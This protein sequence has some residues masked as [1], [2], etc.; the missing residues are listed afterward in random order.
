[1]YTI[2][3]TGF[4]PLCLNL[5]FLVVRAAPEVA[6]FLNQFEGQLARAAEVFS[7][8]HVGTTS[9]P[10]SEWI[11]LSMASEASSLS[12]IS[13][14]LAQFREAGP[15]AGLDPQSIQALKWDH[16]Q[17]KEDIES[18]LSRR[19]S[20]RSRIVATNEKEAEWSR[21]KPVSADSGCTTRLEEKVLA[22]L[23]AALTCL[24]DEE[25]S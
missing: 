21:Q 19:Q 10:S 12:L 6:A 14:I 23:N 2:W 16:A 1:M 18:L 7:A 20:L 17:V 11:T 13:F 24:A 4:L 5:L 22:E 15:S 25:D 3:T 9:K 8:P